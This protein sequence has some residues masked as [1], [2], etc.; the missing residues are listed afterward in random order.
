MIEKGKYKF[1]DVLVVKRRGWFTKKMLWLCINEVR[2]DDDSSHFLGLTNEYNEI[3]FHPKE[4][5]E[6]IYPYLQ[7]QNRIATF[8][9]QPQLISLDGFKIISDEPYLLPK[10]HWLRLFTIIDDYQYY[11]NIKFD[12]ENNPNIIIQG[13]V[14]ANEEGTRIICIDND[15]GMLHCLYVASD[16]YI[17][18]KKHPRIELDSIITVNGYNLKSY[19][20]PKMLRTCRKMANQGITAKINLDINTGFSV[21]GNDV[22]IPRQSE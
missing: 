1:G 17:T 22:I 16:G 9:Y 13:M 21:Y 19:L 4:S 20:D 6:L 10:D 2:F 18:F 11:E 3:P 15:F 5:R 8:Y 14:Y 12:I 7:F